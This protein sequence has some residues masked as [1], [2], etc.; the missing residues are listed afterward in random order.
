M[1]NLVTC[2]I[3]SSRK[4]DPIK[5]LMRLSRS[6]T[7]DGIDLDVHNLVKHSILLKWMKR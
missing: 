3:N 5:L 2:H 7:M 6:L 4:Q 1:N